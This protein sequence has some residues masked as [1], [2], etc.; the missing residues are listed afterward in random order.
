MLYGFTGAAAGF[1]QVTLLQFAEFANGLSRGQGVMQYVNGVHDFFVGGDSPD[2]QAMVTK[3]YNLY[4]W[5][6][7]RFLPYIDTYINAP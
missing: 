1:A 4:T 2:D 7:S 3:G 5:G 6:Y